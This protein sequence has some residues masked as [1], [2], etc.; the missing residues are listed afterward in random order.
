MKHILMLTGCAFALCLILSCGAARAQ[1]AAEASAASGDAAA[2]GDTAATGDTAPNAD[3]AK[4]ADADKIDAEVQEFNDASPEDRRKIMTKALDHLNNMSPAEVKALVEA[5]KQ[6][7]TTMGYDQ[8]VA[9]EHDELQ[10]MTPFQR[11]SLLRRWEGELQRDPAYMKLS[12]E[13]KFKALQQ[14]QDFG[15]D[16]K[17]DEADKENGENEAEP[18]STG[19]R[20]FATSP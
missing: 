20:L 11:Q 19:T 18:P 5:Q 15:K 12:A 17:K 8:M 16:D 14:L 4:Q 10:S 6:R 1:E 3:E 13:D 7:Y 9:E 2:A